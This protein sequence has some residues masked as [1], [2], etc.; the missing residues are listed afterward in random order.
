MSL[1]LEVC[2]IAVALSLDAMIVACCWSATQK[3]VTAAHVMKFAVAFG[4][5][6]ALMPVIGWIAGDA[7]SSLI[8]AWD[9]W[10]AFGLLALVALNMFKEAFGSDADDDESAQLS[11]S[12][13]ISWGTLL[14]LAV[15][16]SLD[17]LAVGFSFALADYPI[18]WPAAAIG[19]ICF[20]LT[21]LAVLLGRT[22]SQKAAQHG[23]KLSI[24]G[25]VILL[26][27]GIKILSDH[28]VFG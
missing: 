24:L 14:T 27:I 9:H 1:V 21:A 23:S 17:A 26:A 10:V 2:G 20:V 4:F 12:E 28:G 6:Q 15:A 22:L 16:T 11:N 25:G 8:S 7:F 3:R 13:H 5:F 18:V 19:I